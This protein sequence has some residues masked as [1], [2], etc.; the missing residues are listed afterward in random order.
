MAVL[1][2]QAAAG[3]TLMRREP[4]NPVIPIDRNHP[5]RAVHVANAAVLTPQESPDGLWRLYLR[6][7]GFFP[8]EGGDPESHYHDTIGVLT[9]EAESFSP[10]G[11][12]KEHPGNPILV[13]GPGESY[14]G[15]HLLDCT[16]VWGRDAEG[17]DVLVMFYKAVS[18]SEGGSLAGAWSTDG[19]FSFTKFEP[20][21]LQKRI[22]PCDAVYHEGRYYIFY[23]DTKYDPEKRKAT[24]RLKT[25]LAVTDDPS[26]FAE[27]PR[28]LALDT[29]PKGSF[30]HV[31]VHGGRIFRLNGRWY[32][33]YQCSARHMDYPERFHVAW[34]EDLLHWTKVD[35]PRPFFERGQAGQWDEGAIWYGEVFEYRN[36]LYMYYEGWGSGR[37][38][39]DREKPYVAGG[40]SQTGLASVAVEG[41]LRWCGHDK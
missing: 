14:D 32:M 6:G 35:N 13:H 33:V 23:G 15:K 25:Y 40:R 30:D 29:G 9:Q 28:R 1:C 2:V 41:F 36:T 10:F 5:W 12:W 3:D 39:Y 11:P 22:G 27:A 26:R 24:S 38:G 7:S 20:N 21:P 8:E 34:S 37:P 17:N 16:P 4:R 19:G 18:Y 31:S